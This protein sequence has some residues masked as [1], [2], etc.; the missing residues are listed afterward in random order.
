VEGGRAKGEQRAKQE[1]VPRLVAAYFDLGVAADTAGQSITGKGKK[2]TKDR[3]LA[4]MS[5]SFSFRFA[6][7]SLPPS[8]EVW[9]EG[10]KKKGEKPT[11]RVR[12]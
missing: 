1:F 9:D 4:R 12:D 11:N 8:I 6:S 5:V 3:L 2:K 7:L 10:R